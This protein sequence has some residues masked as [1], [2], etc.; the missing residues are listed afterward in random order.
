MLVQA[1]GFEWRRRGVS[2]VAA[3]ASTGGARMSGGG[4][5]E[6]GDAGLGRGAVMLNG[7]RGD[8]MLR[9]GVRSRDTGYGLMI[10]GDSD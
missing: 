4:L 5:A 9:L 7:A 8:L 2:L 10:G 6:T 3:A 1:S